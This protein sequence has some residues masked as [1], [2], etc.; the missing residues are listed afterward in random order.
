MIDVLRWYLALSLVG[1]I[2]LPLTFKLFGKLPTRGF[3]LTGWLA[4][5]QPCQSNSSAGQPGR[6]QLLCVSRSAR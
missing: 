5:Q 3:A 6:N 2:N 1:L 4:G